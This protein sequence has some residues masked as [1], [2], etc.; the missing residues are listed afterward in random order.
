MASAAH[1]PSCPLPLPQLS[2]G[3][4]LK[5]QM[6]RPQGPPLW[7]SSPENGTKGGD[8]K[9][10]EQLLEFS[11]QNQTRLYLDFVLLFPKGAGF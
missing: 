5:E 10:R 7:R 11:F 9:S 8:S 3:P 1:G 6:P 4:R 2:G